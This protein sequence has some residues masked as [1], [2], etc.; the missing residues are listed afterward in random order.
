MFGVQGGAVNIQAYL[1]NR[2]NKRDNIL[3]NSN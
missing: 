3:I 2:T 1:N